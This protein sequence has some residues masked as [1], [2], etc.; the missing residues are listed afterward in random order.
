MSVLCIGVFFVCVTPPS[1]SQT[2]ASERTYLLK[3]YSQRH[4]STF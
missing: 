3:N 4:R 1:S 2:S